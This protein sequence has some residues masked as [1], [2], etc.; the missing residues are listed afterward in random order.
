MT[1]VIPKITIEGGPC[2]G[3]TT[4]LSRISSWLLE[5]GYHPIIVP[6]AATCLINSGVQ[7]D[8][9]EFQDFVLQ[10]IIKSE[11]I[12]ENVAQSGHYT[13]PILIYDSAHMRGQA[14]VTKEE[15]ATVLKRNGLNEVTARD[16]FTGR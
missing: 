11:Q 1:G 9:P 13:N 8:H 14:Y 2:A 3:K 12:R 15:F 6:E 16:S 5:H 7:K 10:E 4:A